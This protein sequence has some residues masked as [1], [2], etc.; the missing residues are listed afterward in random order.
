MTPPGRSM[1]SP[2]SGGQRERQREVQGWSLGGE[3]SR[4]GGQTKTNPVVKEEKVFFDS[5]E[6]GG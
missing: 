2:P 6:G 4:P 5:D 1:R 3:R